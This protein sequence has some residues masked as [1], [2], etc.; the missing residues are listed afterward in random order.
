MKAKETK[1]GLTLTISFS[2]GY[3]WVSNLLL[4]KLQKC[5]EEAELGKW[6]IYL[7][8]RLYVVTN[9]PKLDNLY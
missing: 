9:A 4:R 6:V 5:F 8:F 1:L 2:L 7:Y 3:K